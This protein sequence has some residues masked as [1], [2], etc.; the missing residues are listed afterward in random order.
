MFN[1]I[2]KKNDLLKPLLSDIFVVVT[3]TLEIG[4]RSFEIW[5]YL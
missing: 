2:D 1:S 5:M 4:I 3:E